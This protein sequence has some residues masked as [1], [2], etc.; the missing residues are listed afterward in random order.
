M[1]TTFDKIRAI[2]FHVETLERIVRGLNGGGLPEH[3]LFQLE[4]TFD[5]ESV[6]RH[7]D[8]LGLHGNIL[9][10]VHIDE[11]PV[12]VQWYASVTPVS[13]VSSVELGQS[14]VPSA[15]VDEEADLP[16]T[17]PRGFPH[18]TDLTVVLSFEGRAILELEPMVCDDPQCELDHGI[19]GTKKNES[20]VMTFEEDTDNSTAD[21]AMTFVSALSQAMAQ[22]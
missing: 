9:T 16:P 7:F 2:G 22:Q 21:E 19:G 12:G 8:Y 3:S 1:T 13:S 15:Y 10:A 20:L 5:D 4:A 6:F 11:L 14:T 18:N 17:H